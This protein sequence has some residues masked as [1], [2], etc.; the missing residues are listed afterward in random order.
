M[1]I[2]EIE[3]LNNNMR[4]TI[5][6]QINAYSSENI[7]L[8]R[9]SELLATRI[10]EVN[11]DEIKIDKLLKEINTD[12]RRGVYKQESETSNQQIQYVLIYVYFELILFYLF[13]SSFFANQDYMKP[14]PVILLIL[15][16]I[17]PFVM[18]Y[19]IIFF[20]NLYL[21]FQK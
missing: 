14:L 21:S 10:K 18:K 5:T 17:L 7:S 11:R 9:M 19:I 1:K 3:K 4:E 2:D 20:Y 12:N 15:Y 6:T 8:F 16:M 13:S